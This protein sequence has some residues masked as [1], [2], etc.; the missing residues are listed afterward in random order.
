MVDAQTIGVLV[1]AASVT[2]AA[3]YYIMNLRETTKNRRATLSMNVLQSFFSE[4]G[5]HRMMDLLNMQ[6]SDFDDYVKKYDSSVNVENYAKRQAYWQTCDLLGYLYKT[7][8][9]DIQTIYNVGGF[10]I[11]LVWRK[12][13]TIIEEYRRWEYP[14]DYLGNFEYLANVLS[15][16][17]ED[18]DIEINRKLDI[19]I[20]THIKPSP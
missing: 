15:K 19:S 2:V 5:N 8:V 18:R 7:G 9:L 10:G 6:W 14:S 13:K 17:R 3:V 4:E 16:M 12:F 11:L 20:S 1:T